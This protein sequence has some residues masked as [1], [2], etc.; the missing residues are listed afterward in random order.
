MTNGILF[1]ACQIIS[2]CFKNVTATAIYPCNNHTWM[3]WVKQNYGGTIIWEVGCRYENGV[4][5]VCGDGSVTILPG[6]VNGDGERNI[7]D[8]SRLYA[9]NQESTL[10]DSDALPYADVN[11]DGSVDIADTARLY[12]Y[13]KGTYPLT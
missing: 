13:V 7:I 6:D 11:G 5:T 10:L 2:T 3:D 8:V 1:C 12:A 9:H 4:C